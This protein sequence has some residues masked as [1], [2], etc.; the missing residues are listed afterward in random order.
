MTRRPA[1][2]R[3]AAAAAVELAVVLP[4]LLTI[5]L[6]GVDFGRFTHTAVAAADAAR[7]ACEFAATHPYTA[8][9][10]ATWGDRVRA[11]ALDDLAG[12]PRFESARATVTVDVS[13]D[14]GVTRVAVAVAYPF[15]TTVG[16]PGVPHRV[17]VSRS[18]A[19]PLARP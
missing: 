10:Q 17:D 15:E 14:D 4:V 2:P 18:A 8:A 6:G 16:W 13:E 19:T 12:V 9:T 3:A 1:R 5:T 7:C 11:A